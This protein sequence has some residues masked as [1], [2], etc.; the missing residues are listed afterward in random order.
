MID[1]YIAYGVIAFLMIMATWF[2]CN[3][4]NWIGLQKN[5]IFVIMLVTAMVTIVLDLLLIGAGHVFGD[6]RRPAN[7]AA[8]MFMYIGMILILYLLLLYD[9]AAAGRL[10]W[11]KKGWFRVLQI[12]LAVCILTVL[13]GPWSGIALLQYQPERGLYSAPGNWIQLAGLALCIIIGSAVIFSG[14]M[15]LSRR[16]KYVLFGS[17]CYLLFDMM[18]Q[19][20]LGVRYVISYCALTVIF[21]LFYLLLHNEDQYKLSSNRCFTREGLGKVIREKANYRRNFGCL[22]I[23]INNIESI[24]NYCTEEDIAEVQHCLGKILQ[25]YCGKHAVYQNHS[26]EYIVMLR[27]Y[28]T[29]QRR[30]KQLLE[31][32]PSY[33]RI[34]NKNIQ[35]LCGFYVLDFADAGY[36]PE[37]FSRIIAC[38]RRMAMEEMD[39]EVLLSYRG[40][41]QSEIEQNL[42]ALRVV[43]QGIQNR[44]FDFRCIPIQA[45]DDRKA[46]SC[47]MILMEY[48]ENDF[49]ISQEILWEVASEMGYAKELGCITC[50]MMCR[51]VQ[52]EALFDKGFHRIHIDISSPQLPGSIAAEQLV[53]IMKQYGVPGERVCIEVT[54]EQHADCQKLREAFSVLHEYGVS[55]LLDQFGVTVCNL[56]EMLSMPFDAVKINHHMVRCYCSGDNQ[57]LRYLVTMLRKQDWI[58]Y[59][60]GVDRKEQIEPLR[61]LD[62]SYIQGMLLSG[63]LLGEKEMEQYVETGGAF[64]SG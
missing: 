26:F 24:T 11:V 52:R 60:D 47:E 17:H 62:V 37:S 59:L 48:R 33:L 2:F 38:M 40:E 25:T 16:E 7:A 5:K 14:R 34:N 8:G 53:N 3:L 35:I 44:Q 15:A 31:E 20:L 55:I 22:G 29:A 30:H 21:M 57:Q 32:I 50:E 18:L 58:I 19:K 12:Y 63:V 61:K 1:M 4:K 41:K 27:D 9:L 13:S 39:R 36:Q 6:V 45:A 51:F 46:I 43:T 54:I 42:E 10:R 64:I 28:E 49:V 56:R 23:C